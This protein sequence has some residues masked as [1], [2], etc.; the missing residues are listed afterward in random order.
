ML[1][2]L[3]EVEEGIF[4]PSANCRHSPQSCALELLA[5]EQ[6]LCI[7][8]EAD[9]ISGDDFDQ[10]LRCRQLAEGY[11]EMVGIVEGVHEIFVERVD[12]LQAREAIQDQ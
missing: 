6:R 4:Q 9:I 11:A 10:M 12:I 3:I 1:A 7:F 2:D 8:E 5:L